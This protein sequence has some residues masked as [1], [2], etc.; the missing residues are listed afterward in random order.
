[1]LD[2]YVVYDTCISKLGRPVMQAGVTMDS[3]FYTIRFKDWIR[4]GPDTISI[5]F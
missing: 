5:H 4:L 3:K 1:V 2:A